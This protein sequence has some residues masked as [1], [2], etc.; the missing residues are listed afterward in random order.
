MFRKSVSK[1]AG[2][3]VHATHVHATTHNL[4]REQPPNKFSLARDSVEDSSKST[5]QTHFEF[6]EFIKRSIILKNF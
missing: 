1:V 6:I 3:Q 2:L 4:K 5:S